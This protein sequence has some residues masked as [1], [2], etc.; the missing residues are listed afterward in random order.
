MHSQFKTEL[1][2]AIKAKNNIRVR[3]IRDVLAAITNELVAEGKT[4]QDQLD[5]EST[6]RVIKR[7]AKQRKE[8]IKQY[9]SANESDMA[10]AER[11]ELEILEQYLPSKMNLGEV[12]AI[13]KT[14]QQEMGVTDKSQAGLLIG[15]VLKETKGQADGNDV[16]AVV[17]RLLEKPAP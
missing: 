6:C 15:A 16:K 1:K 8:A 17:D 4:P 9:E 14:K 5:D 3:T 7:L 13:A 10:K 12:E 11:D 2:E